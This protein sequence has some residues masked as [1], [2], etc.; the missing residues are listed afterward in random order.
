MCRP[1]KF[2]RQP[3]RGLKP[4]S[5]CASIPCAFFSLPQTQ[6]TH[7]GRVLH[8]KTSYTEKI[9]ICAVTGLSSSLKEH[10]QPSARNIHD[11]WPRTLGKSTSGDCLDVWMCTIYG[12]VGFC[13]RQGNLLG[14]APISGHEF[15][16]RLE[17]PFK[18][19]YVL[20]GS[21]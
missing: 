15:D 13:A 12:A 8:L 5:L 3:S 20:D 6:K 21:F 10:K 11:T 7:R 9:Y 1:P 18:D 19:S 16:R 17:Q 2:G 14:S 4:V